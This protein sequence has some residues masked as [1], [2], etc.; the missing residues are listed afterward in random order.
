MVFIALRQRLDTIQALVAQNPTTI[1]KQMI[2]WAG[3]LG[4]ESIV[5]VEGVA[6]APVEEVKS[7][8]VGNVE[9]LVGKVICTKPGLKPRYV[10]YV[11]RGFFYI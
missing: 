2:K 10:S 11:W 1:S 6:Q 4:D 5:L 8:S 3:S 7:V 9:I